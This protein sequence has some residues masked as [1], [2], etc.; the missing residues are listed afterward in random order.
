MTSI[1]GSKVDTIILDIKNDKMTLAPSSVCHM[2]F[3]VFVM[4][5]SA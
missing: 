3:F 4:E 2:A 5:R 1:F